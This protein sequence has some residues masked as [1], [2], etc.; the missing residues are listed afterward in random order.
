MAETQ[1]QNCKFL[2]LRYVPD[3][4][5]SEFVNIGLVLLP[6]QGQPELRFD[7]DWSR[8]RG[9]YPQADIEL[10][11]A[12]RHELSE[13][14][15][16]EAMLK[17]MEDSF[18][19]AL[20]ISEFKAC[21]TTSP[22]EEADKLARIYLEAPRHARAREMSAREVM[23]REMERAFRSTGAWSG[24]QHEIAVSDYTGSGDPLI[25]D[26]GYGHGPTVKLFHATPLKSGVNA[27]KALAFSF[28]AMAQAIQDKH[29]SGTQ[30]T[31]IV[32]EGLDRDNDAVRF[33][34]GALRQQAIEIAAIGELPRL[35]QIAARE[36]GIQ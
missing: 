4:V 1:K 29:G 9:L 7:K 24:M 3:A 21:L 5:K 34:L 31:A 32:E 15:D 25:I 13:E 28:P 19:N 16:I 22:A 17:K 27:A 23:R 35:A 14:K 12:F 20:Q 8:L 26:C 30:L 18:S 33:S 2:L 10:L 36:L 11:E 6:P